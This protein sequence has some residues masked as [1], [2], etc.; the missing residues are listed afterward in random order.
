[1]SNIQAYKESFTGLSPQY[2]GMLEKISGNFP[3]IA[4][5]TKNF[6]KTQSQFMDS[7]LT[8]NHPTP[9]RNLRQI[10]AEINKSKMA[11]DEAYFGIKK[12]ELDIQKKEDELRELNESGGF[13]YDKQQ[14]I[15]SEYL[16]VEIGELQS[17]ID[18][19][20]GF[21]EGAVRRISAYM[22][23]YNSILKAIGKEELTEED[24][25]REEERYHI[26]KMF[27]QAL[28][29]ARS[30]GGVIDEGNQIYAHQIGI[31]GTVAQAEVSS[32]LEAEY[33]LLKKNEIPAHAMTMKW[34]N[35]MANKYEGS[36]KVYAEGKGMT[37]LDTDSLA[38][39]QEDKNKSKKGGKRKK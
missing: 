29:A 19:T 34:L 11:L 10:L 33:S 31:N 30:H 35:V 6:N 4:R 17:Q 3:V 24:F 23:Q 20:M 8:V 28:C 26:M 18:N 13:L 14:L 2:Q 1:M 36:A 16:K 5:A 15:K 37:L 9:L 12:K 21:V 25:E 22:N 32:Y 7:M 38:T 39:L 27:E